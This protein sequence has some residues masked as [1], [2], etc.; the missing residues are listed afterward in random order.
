MVSESLYALEVRA[1]RH[2]ATRLAFRIPSAAFRVVMAIISPWKW[3]FASLA[4]VLVAASVVA[5]MRM[6]MRLGPKPAGSW[7][8]TS[9]STNGSVERLTRRGGGLVT[10]RERDRSGDFIV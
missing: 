4:G 3:L 9:A 2:G 1:R 6:A 8:H 5:V 7:R 10:V